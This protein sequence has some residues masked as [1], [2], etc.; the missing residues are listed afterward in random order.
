MKTK[1]Y[2]D[3]TT[4]EKKNQYMKDEI[5]RERYEL[6]IIQANY[7]NCE[8]AKSHLDEKLKIFQDT[9]T[10]VKKEIFTKRQII[11]IMSTNQSFR[12]GPSKQQNPYAMDENPL[13]NFKSNRSFNDMIME[14]VQTNGE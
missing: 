1:Y 8:E 9:L 12:R 7:V 2:R 13:A 11:W 4:V 10:M 3:M 14:T 6:R 5:D